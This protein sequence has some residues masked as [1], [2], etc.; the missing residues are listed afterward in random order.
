MLLIASYIANGVLGV[1]F[2]TKP[3]LSSMVITALLLLFIF[4]PT[5]DPAG[6]AVLALAATVAAA[7]KYLLAIRGR[8]IFNPAAAAAFIVGAIPALTGNTFV[9][10]WI[11]TPALLPFTLIGALAI[12][13]RTRRLWLGAVFVVVAT[14]VVGRDVRRRPARRSSTA[15]RSPC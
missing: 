15:S 9:V 7:T 1:I 2:R 3:Q 11:G 12:L 6:L 5:I 14:A 4:Q 8:H 10:W 13:F